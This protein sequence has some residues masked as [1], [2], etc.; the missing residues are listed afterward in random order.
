MRILSAAMLA[1]LAIVGGPTF[2]QNHLPVPCARLD[3][4]PPPSYH[5]PTPYVE[6]IPRKQDDIFARAFLCRETDAGLGVPYGGGCG[7]LGDMENWIVPE[8]S[9]AR[10]SVTLVN[11][12]KADTYYAEL[13]EW[14]FEPCMAVGAAI[15][16]PSLDQES[17][18]LGIEREH[19]AALMLASRES[20]IRELS[21]TL[22]SGSKNPGWET[23]RGFYPSILRMCLQ[24]FLK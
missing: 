12:G 8:P 9:A 24:S 21:E 1:A 22:A 15:D 17:V 19:V 18:D 20:A 3:P 11:T 2:A 10:G 7:T 6:L 5:C 4:S 16:V 13:V 14:A 23:R